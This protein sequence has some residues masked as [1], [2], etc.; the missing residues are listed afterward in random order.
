VGFDHSKR[1][2]VRS[3]ARR[4]RPATFT[5]TSHSSRATPV[6]DVDGEIQLRESF[7]VKEDW[8]VVVA[9]VNLNPVIVFS[10]FLSSIG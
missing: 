9:R 1:R 7:S 6:V 5:V 4:I 8:P 3:L 2:I 10:L